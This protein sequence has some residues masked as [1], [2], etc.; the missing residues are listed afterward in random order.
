MWTE[1]LLKC[2]LAKLWPPTGDSQC[3]IYLAGLKTVADCEEK[4]D[5]AKC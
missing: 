4:C 1:K 5:S 2:R 3:D